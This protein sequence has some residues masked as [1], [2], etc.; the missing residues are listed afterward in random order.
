MQHQG[1]IALVYPRISQ[2]GQS[3]YSIP[4]HIEAAQR[5]AAA[6]GYTIAG[7][8]PDEYSGEELD[9]PALSA[10]IEAI[11]RT[12]ATVVLVHD[13]DRLGR[14]VY[15]Q[16]ITEHQ[17]EGAGARV[18]FV[19]EPYEGDSGQLLKAVKGGI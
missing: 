7:V 19:L 5:L 4:T 9:R 10:L 15:I 1:T 2:A 14:E 6:R 11:P 16:A 3:A 18:E 8:Y 12:G 13:I 17:I